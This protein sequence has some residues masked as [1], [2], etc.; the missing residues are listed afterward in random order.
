MDYRKNAMTSVPVTYNYKLEPGDATCYR[1]SIQFFP[2]DPEHAYILA[3]GVGN[4]PE[5][6][7]KVSIDMPGGTGIATLAISS[8]ADL[9]G[10]YQGYAHSHGMG[11]VNSYTLAAV[12]LACQVLVKAPGDLDAAAVNMLQAPVLLGIADN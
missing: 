5:N 9:H 11:N 2:E 1:F 3:S 12:L 8:L 7:V 4:H 6:Y 10:Y